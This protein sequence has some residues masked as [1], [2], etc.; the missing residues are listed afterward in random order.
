MKTSDVSV[1]RKF[2]AVPKRKV[3]AHI[4]RRFCIYWDFIFFENLSSRKIFKVF[5]AQ[6]DYFPKIVTKIQN[7]AQVGDFSTFVRFMEQELHFRIRF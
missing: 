2:S 4:E 1:F 5:M 6:I 3:K 7:F